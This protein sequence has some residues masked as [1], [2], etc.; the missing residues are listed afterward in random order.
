MV[1]SSEPFSFGFLPFHLEY[2]FLKGTNSASV[3]S[4]TCIERLVYYK[5]IKNRKVVSLQGKFS[6]ISFDCAKL[7]MMN[8]DYDE[9]NIQL[10]ST[11]SILLNHRFMS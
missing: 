1:T 8:T 5:S 6:L 7:N 11:Q 10:Q 4:V 9:A 2:V 3:V